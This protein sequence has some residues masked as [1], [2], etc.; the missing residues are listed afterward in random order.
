MKPRITLTQVQ[1]QHSPDCVLYPLEQQTLAL[2]SR[3]SFP[4]RVSLPPFHPSFNLN[5]YYFVAL[6]A[7]RLS[8][9]KG[10]EFQE[11][12]RQDKLFSGSWRGWAGMVLAGRPT[13]KWVTSR[14]SRHVGKSISQSAVTQS[15]PQLLGSS[16]CQSLRLSVPRSSPES[17]RPHVGAQDAGW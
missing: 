10:R 12:Y 13:I 7:L 5:F 17:L 15:V 2:A 9:L 6:I 16:V 14:R 1:H 8:H 3:V 11:N 4:C